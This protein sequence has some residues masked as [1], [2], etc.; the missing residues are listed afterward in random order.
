MLISLKFFVACLGMCFVY[1]CVFHYCPCCYSLLCFLLL[2]VSVF[3][4]SHYSLLV[5]CFDLSI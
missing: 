3:V 5:D 1:C 2:L 4:E